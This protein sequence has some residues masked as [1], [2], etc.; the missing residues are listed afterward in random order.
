[1]YAVRVAKPIGSA[2][3]AGRNIINTDCLPPAGMIG[4]T[5][6][7]Y[8]GRTWVDKTALNGSS[9]HRGIVAVAEFVGVVDARPVEKL[10]AE[11]GIFC[12]VGQRIVSV[13]GP[14]GIKAPLLAAEALHSSWWTGPIGWVLAGIVPVNPVVACRGHCNAWRIQPGELLRL[15]SRGV[16]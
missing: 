9:H 15:D 11:D 4:R 6:A 7:I 13:A 12:F 16:L 10:S 8:Q 14:R 5:I 1:M 3:A 2:I